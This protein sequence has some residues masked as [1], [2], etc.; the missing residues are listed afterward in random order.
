M[1][2]LLLISESGSNSSLRSF[3]VAKFVFFC[4]WIDGG[5]LLES[6]RGRL[7]A[8]FFC[9]YFLVVESFLSKDFAASSCVGDISFSISLS[10]SLGIAATLLCILDFLTKIFIFAFFWQSLSKWSFSAQ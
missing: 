4:G 6:E 10:E 7:L 5:E 2:L 3:S 1:L 9:S 8:S